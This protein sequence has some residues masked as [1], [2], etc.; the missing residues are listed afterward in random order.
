MAIRKAIH[1]TYK[2]YDALLES[3]RFRVADCQKQRQEAEARGW[4]LAVKTYDE[5]IDRF[6]ALRDD[7]IN[8]YNS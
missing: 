3:I 2:Q 7:I 5:D 4:D 8:Q 6:H 1:L